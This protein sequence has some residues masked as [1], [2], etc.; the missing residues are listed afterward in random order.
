MVRV[1][2]L[3]IDSNERGSLKDAVVRL[4]EKQGIV[5]KQNHLQGMGDYKVGNGNVECKRT[6][7]ATNGKLRC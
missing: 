6:F 7:D 3:I 5:V 2:P 1:P 4:A